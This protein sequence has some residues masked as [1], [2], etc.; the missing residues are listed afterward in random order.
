MEVD[1]VFCIHATCRPDTPGHS[2]DFIG[3]DYLKGFFDEVSVE[4]IAQLQ[5][6]KS[7]TKI[8]LP[9]NLFPLT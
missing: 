6:V 1:L 5:Q 7:A 2:R 9:Q 4:I 3:I 8:K